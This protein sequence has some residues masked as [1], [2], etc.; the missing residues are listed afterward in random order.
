MVNL[1][2][3]PWREHM[4]AYQQKRIIKMLLCSLFLTGFFLA[5]I[6]FYILR[7]ENKLNIHLLKLHEGI[8]FNLTKG[9]T[10]EKNLNAHQEDIIKKLIDY[11]IHTQKLFASLTTYTADFCFTEMQRNK[12]T[13]TFM[14][15][16]RSVR[17][18]TDFLRNFRAASSFSEIKIDDINQQEND[19]VYFR[20]HAFENI[21]S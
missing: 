6:H 21:E 11:H 20:F 10:Q 5:F 16:A 18:L 12:N 4:H 7:Q 17:N 13:M 9:Y 15:K 8:N 1:N 2:L 3:F 14:G 19:D